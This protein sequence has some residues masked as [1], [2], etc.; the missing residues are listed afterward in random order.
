MTKLLVSVRDVAEAEMAQQAGV[1]LIDVKEP[2]SGSLGA[3][4][5]QVWQDIHA[6]L[7]GCVPWSVAC[8]E[9]R[10]DALCRAS[11]VPEGCSY[12]KCGLAGLG[13]CEDWTGRWLQWSEALPAGTQAVAV[14]YVDDC[15]AASPTLSEVLQF[16]EK[17][18]T[19]VLLDT[20][21][22]SQGDLFAHVAEAELRRLCQWAKLDRRQIVLAG[23]LAGTSLSR[24]IQLQPTY[25]GVRGAGCAGGRE[26]VLC[27]SRLCAI[28]EEVRTG[29]F[30]AC[31]APDRTSPSKNFK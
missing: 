26:T 29:T 7:Q 5:P 8:G 28:V 18:S 17:H 23:S 6:L 20:F 22:K 15:Q 11:H 19:T 30:V 27:P 13:A 31:S 14:A 25:V 16:A 4:S 3:A 24:A 10:D 1:D 12:A 2:H 9:L 21:D